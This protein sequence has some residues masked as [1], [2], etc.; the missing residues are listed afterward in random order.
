MIG[1]VPVYIPDSLDV[2]E[3]GHHQLLPER[4]PSGW[5]L[6]F[7]QGW[8]VGQSQAGVPSLLPLN[9]DGSSREP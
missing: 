8:L 7:L 4:D 9:D 5:E 3:I 1:G 6:P 2:A